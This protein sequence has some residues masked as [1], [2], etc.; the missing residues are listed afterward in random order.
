MPACL[1]ACTSQA[2]WRRRL[3]FAHTLAPFTPQ[4]VLLLHA[5]AAGL[6]IAATVLGGLYIRQSLVGLLCLHTL[7][8]R[9]A[10]SLVR[11]LQ[12]RCTALLRGGACCMR[13]PPAR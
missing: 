12:V 13:L 7:P 11:T 4:V 9:E 5:G 6:W 10:Y 8:T 3:T 2:P 1:P